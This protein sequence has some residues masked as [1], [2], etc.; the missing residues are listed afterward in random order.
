MATSPPHG[1]RLSGPGHDGADSPD[2]TREDL[3]LDT[4]VSLAEGLATRTVD[5]ALETLLDRSVSVLGTSS[6]GLVLSRDRGRTQVLVSTAG[7]G[8]SARALLEADDDT[9]PCARSARTGEAVLVDDLAAMA[10]QWP[11]WAALAR[12][13]DVACVH[14][15]PLRLPGATAGALVL[16]GDSPRQLSSRD[17]RAAQAL[18]DVAAVT[19]VTDDQV[20]SAEELTAQLQTALDSRV[21]IE[22][23]KGIVAATLHI[24]VDEAFV[25]L[26]DHSRS[27]NRRIVELAADLSTGRTTVDSLRRRRQ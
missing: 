20:R 13:L 4:F 7:T 16:F 8:R 11:S 18:A 25:V 10:S 26:R 23:A 15:L 22:Q 12:E 14:A 24:S 21:V 9:N 6:S 17:Q 19:V 1:T 5:A 2:P 27:T 3:L